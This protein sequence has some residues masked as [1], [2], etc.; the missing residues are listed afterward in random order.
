MSVLLF[1]VICTAYFH[2]RRVTAASGSSEKTSIV[3]RGKDEIAQRTP[4]FLERICW[5]GRL[6]AAENLIR[7]KQAT[8]MALSTVAQRHQNVAV[9]GNIQE[10]QWED[11]PNDNR[12]THAVE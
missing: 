6:A 4:W 1:L 10:L 5:R 3:E 9:G 11:E 12:N 2:L 8:I 7:T